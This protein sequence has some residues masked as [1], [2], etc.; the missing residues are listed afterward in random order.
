M[1]ALVRCLKE[2]VKPGMSVVA[3]QCRHHATPAHAGCVGPAA[4][5]QRLARI[6]PALR[7]GGLHAARRGDRGAPTH[8][9]ALTNEEIESLAFAA[10]AMTGA[11]YLTAR[12]LFGRQR[13]GRLIQ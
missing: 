6:R 8:I 1:F 4:R 7:D 10:P 11:E 5:A 2:D 12:V 13:T 9:L 3:A